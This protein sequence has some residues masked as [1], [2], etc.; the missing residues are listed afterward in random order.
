MPSIQLHNFSGMSP[1]SNRALQKGN[2]ATY[3]EN[4][5]LWHGT[6]L[7]FREPK[8]IE[9][10]GAPN[11]T[12][13]Q[14]EAGWLRFSGNVDVVGGLPGCLRLIAVGD[15]FLSPSWALAQDAVLGSWLRLGLPIPA[16]V[17]VAAQASDATFSISQN[18]TT[19]AQH[20]STPSSTVTNP[21]G[22][23]A[24]GGAAWGGGVTVINGSS[25]DKTLGKSPVEWRSYIITYK[26]SFGNEGAPSLPC[27]RFA[28]DDGK[29]ATVSIPATPASPWDVAT[30]CLYRATSGHEKNDAQI[31]ADEFHLV[32]ELPAGTTIFVDNLQNLDIDAEP[33]M[34]YE[35]T[36]A[37]SY[38]KHIVAEPN[39]TQLAG[40]AGREVWFCEPHEFHAWPEKYTLTLDDDIVGLCWTDAGLF[41]MTDGAPYWIDRTAD[42]FGYRKVM[43]MPESLPCAS[44]RS[45]CQTP[46]AGC[47]YVHKDGLVVLS[48]ERR[49]VV[50]TL[51]LWEED[52][53]HKQ[54]P[55]TFVATVH[56]GWWFGFGD[57]GAWMLDIKDT[58]HQ[59][60]DTPLVALSLR[61]SA[62]FRSRDDRF[63][64][65]LH[66]G[67]CE[68]DAGD[69]I[70]DWVWKSRLSVSPSQVNFAA[71]KAV[72]ERYPHEYK[73]SPLPVHIKFIM[74]DKVMYERDT[75]HSRP[76][77]L[78]HGMRNIG[79]EI[80]VSSNNKETWANAVEIRE[81]HLASSMVELSEIGRAR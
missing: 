39:G 34:S 28:V 44:K 32:A 29:S 58:I 10:H 36:P 24:N 73:P 53:W 45:I 43:R 33:C 46:D 35:F 71:F 18:G 64:L 42:E 66:D 72:F 25:F 79:F 11:K 21:S 81:I 41:V 27:D 17:S 54:D 67:I 55:D 5:R 49:A 3:C 19:P 51:Q 6:L 15:G 13:Y 75:N 4:V 14:S 74:D 48:G 59:G 63:Y 8:V 50:A 56:N 9:P 31:T 47:C 70:L 16:S 61:P 62:L 60:S 2:D 76:S 37:P 52:D 12:I 80:E 7:G 65:A 30:I 69:H 57:V 26:D 38:L 22:S 77:R 78:P 20:V 68:W 40:A 23:F 1:R